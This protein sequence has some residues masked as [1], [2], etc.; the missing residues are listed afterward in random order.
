[1][2]AKFCF[3]N[4]TNCISKRINNK[5]I[6]KYIVDR[7]NSSKEKIIYLNIFFTVNKKTKKTNV[8]NK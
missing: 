8:Y 6:K 5:I 3:I 2:A 4:I 7:N 1:M